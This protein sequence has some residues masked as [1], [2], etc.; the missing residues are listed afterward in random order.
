MIAIRLTH[1]D[2]RTTD[3]THIGLYTY[4]ADV[5]NLLTQTSNRDCSHKYEIR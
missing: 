4:L 3:I 5:I 1:E 2:Y